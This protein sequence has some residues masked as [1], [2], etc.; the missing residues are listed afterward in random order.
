MPVLRILR[1]KYSEFQAS[2]YH[3]MFSRPG[4][5]SKWDSSKEML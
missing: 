1:K 5:V 2:F 4:R 3:I